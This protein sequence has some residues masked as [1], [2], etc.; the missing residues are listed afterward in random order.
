MPCVWQAEV[1]AVAT[2]TEFVQAWQA[3]QVVASTQAAPT[4]SFVARLQLSPWVVLQSGVVVQKRAVEVADY[5]TS[6]GRVPK[7]RV[8]V[9][10]RGASEPLDRNATDAKSSS[11]NRRIEIV[12]MQD[13]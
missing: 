13:A 7:E 8:G 6:T 5:L 3:P 9:A 10:A 11:R 2:Q 1:V 4:H 12:V